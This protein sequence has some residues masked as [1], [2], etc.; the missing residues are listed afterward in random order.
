M[1]LAIELL[2]YLTGSKDK[3][4]GVTEYSKY[5]SLDYQKLSSKSRE[6]VC[7]EFK[8]V[9]NTIVIKRDAFDSD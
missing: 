2:T 5:F 8:N 4:K 9:L 7:N 6:E 3:A 1:T